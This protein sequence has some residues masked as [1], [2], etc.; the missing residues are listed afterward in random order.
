MLSSEDVV[1]LTKTVW[2]RPGPGGPFWGPSWEDLCQ[3]GPGH[4][5]KRKRVAN[6]AI[7]RRHLYATIHSALDI[8]VLTQYRFKW[9]WGTASLIPAERATLGAPIIEDLF[10]GL[11]QISVLEK[12]NFPICG[13]KCVAFV[14]V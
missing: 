10:L 5:R 11:P 3:L 7:V 4:V 14:G 13:C 9:A 2:Q 12:N 6:S 8:L 1:Y